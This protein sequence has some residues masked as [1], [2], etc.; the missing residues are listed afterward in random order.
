MCCLLQGIR[1]IVA[2][3]GQEAAEAIREGET[4]ANQLAAAQKLQ[5][6]ELEKEVAALKQV[7][8]SAAPYYHDQE[9]TTIMTKSIVMTSIKKTFEVLTIAV[10]A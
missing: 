6:Q 2:V 4:L 3:T 10:E 1:R 7:S 8:C 5:G 9:R